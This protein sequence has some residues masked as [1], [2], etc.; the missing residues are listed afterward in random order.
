MLQYHGPS[1]VTYHFQ[2]I[3]R[4]NPKTEDA[5]EMIEMLDKVLEIQNV[6]CLNKYMVF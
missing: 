2:A 3:D 6:S 4:L 1:F 5:A